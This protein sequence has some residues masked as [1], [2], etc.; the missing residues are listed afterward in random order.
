MSWRQK[1]RVELDWLGMFDPAMIIVR[2]NDVAT[3]NSETG[4]GRAGVS[5]TEMIEAILD[6]EE[7]GMARSNDVTVVCSVDHVH[8]GASVEKA[9]R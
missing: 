6:Y 9:A 4:D 7:A 8:P 2:Y 1:R 3:Q 5:L